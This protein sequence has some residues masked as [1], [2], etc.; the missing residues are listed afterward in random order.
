[1]L[2][3]YTPPSASVDAW[4][5]PN[6]PTRI[7][8][9]V[10]I[11]SIIFGSIATLGAG[12]W[13]ASVAL[14]AAEFPNEGGSGPTPLLVG[15]AIVAVT[16]IVLVVLGVALVQRRAWA[17]RFTIYWAWLALL[18]L[19]VFFVLLGHAATQG[20]TTGVGIGELIGCLPFLSYPILVLAL[21]SR[22]RVVAAMDR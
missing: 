2:N 13:L 16:A 11:L 9:V 10:G 14:V 22:P 5:S 12:L 7:P 8:T 4:A 18:E 6:R 20:V 21:L 19:A 15:G 1:M 3:P 17:R